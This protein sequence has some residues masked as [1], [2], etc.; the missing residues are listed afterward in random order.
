MSHCFFAT[1][2]SSSVLIGSNTETVLAT[3]RQSKCHFLAYSSS[4]KTVAA[5]AALSTAVFAQS[6]PK[7][8]ADWSAVVVQTGK[9]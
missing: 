3:T 6:L 8:A 1:S 4:M 5:I 7:F 2:F 9:I